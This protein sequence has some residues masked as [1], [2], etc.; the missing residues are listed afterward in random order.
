METGQLDF[1]RVAMFVQIA[2]AGGVTAAATA[3]KLPKSSVSRGL[4]QL[5][6]DLGAELVVRGSR[7]FRL[8]DAGDAFFQ[9]AAKGLATLSDARDEIR[10]GREEPRGLV[11]VAAPAS[12]VTAFVGPVVAQ[13]IARHPQVNVEL[14][15][16]GR[17]VDPVRDGF[18]LV[19]AF[20]KLKDSSAK[21]RSIGGMETGVFATPDYLRE[22]G[23]PTRPFE[24][25]RHACI[26]RSTSGTKDRWRLSG[27]GG[28]VVVPVE[29][30]IRVDDLVGAF[31]AAA[32]G[33]GLAL[34]PVHLPSG[35]DGT[36]VRVLPDHA[37][38]G[39]SLH[40]LYAGQRHV[41][42]GVKL[43][44]DAIMDHAQHACRAHAKAP[45]GA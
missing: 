2:T 37:V 38:R 40:L 15:V 34:L 23:T 43:L 1:N 18:D 36:L 25:A 30:R 27:P 22:H 33:A 7:S 31:A 26:L 45:D 44:C 28:T 35:Y 6:A 42:L 12:A 39:E 9:A 11:R 4:T 3:L 21:V 10:R 19:I 8:T 29:G 41:P 5:E 24:L 16:T 17:Q 20:G 32:A 14:S 13:F